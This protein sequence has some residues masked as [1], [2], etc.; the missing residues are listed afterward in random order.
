MDELY[1]ERAAIALFEEMLAVDPDARESWIEKRSEGR[2][3]L[4]ARLIAMRD[5]DRV[6]SLRTGGASES[7]EQEA[8]PERIGAYRIVER[9]GRGGMGSVYRGE[10]ET[11]DFA[12][13][14]A[15]KVIKPGLMSEALVERFQRE[16]QTLA[17]LTHPNIAQL[18][19]GGATDAGSPY[20]VM[21]YVDGLPLLQFAEERNLSRKA[22]LALFLDICSAVAFA[23]RNLVVHRDLTPSNVLVTKSGTVKLIDFGIAK[24]AD[25]QEAPVDAV[26]IGSLS[27]T[28]GFA[29][30]ER[31]TSARV[32]TAADIYSL[33]MVLQRLV[34]PK[35]NDVELRAIIGRAT[36]L[37]PSKR[38]LTVDA[39]RA[40]I[41]AWQS[42]HP[43]AAMRAGGGY[44][45]AKYV[46][47]HRPTA[48]AVSLILLALISALTVALIANARTER[49]LAEAERRFQQTRGIAKAM[50][51][52]AYDEV[53]KAPGSTA[54]R[55]ML[56]R[57]G[58]TYLDALAADPDAPLDVKLEAGRGF[59]RL[60]TVI[61]GGQGSQLG[62]LADAETLLDRAEKILAPIA[63][64]SSG[65]RDV[66]IAYADLLLERSG[67]NLYNNN[68]PEKA[69]ALAIEAQRLAKSFAT[70]TP[71][72]ARIYATAIQAEGDSHGWSDDYAG[73]LPIYQKGAAFLNGLPPRI[74]N[75]ADVLSPRSAILRLLGE[76]HHKL[77]HAEEA[78]RALDAA[79]AINQRLVASAPEDPRLLRKLAISEWYR[80]VVHRTNKR[81]EAAR[82]SVASAAQHAAILA[83]RDPRDAG[84]LSL[85]AAIIDLQS[86]ILADHKS[87]ADSYAKGDQV[88]AIHE[89]LI[90]LGGNAVGPR[91]ARATALMTTGANH[92][93]GRDYAGACKLWRMAK[94]SYLEMER[95]GQLTGSDRA[96]W[97]KNA[98]SFT[99]DSCDGGAPRAGVGPEV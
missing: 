34:S 84:S 45:L 66:V 31:M 63:A 76:A 93:N 25:D 2:P 70:Q 95:S 26:S 41:D 32:S 39:L 87:F 89:R 38:Y 96:G 52:D 37:D 97:G 20:I 83:G 12:H 14:A 27:L 71:E 64:H 4:R 5:A 8:D 43:V 28:P 73:A 81:D 75:T 36:A 22:R 17:Q 74:A 33:G 30:P 60:A 62:K 99:R 80:A 19:D 77:K 82:Q 98:M 68:A 7:L 11:G 40:D 42:K 10:R 90:A 91:R 88:L 49:A 85:Y 16:R 56:A 57:Q 3:A 35:P 48:I 13:V 23:H 50:L 51:F 9:I 54:A 29:A 1:V 46:A 58:L 65:N 92:Y 24:P 18:Y 78:R 21:E 47:R 15:I 59:K 61:G 67:T 69:R 6:A 72:T 94:A 86:Q 55:V 44:R 79:V 53:S